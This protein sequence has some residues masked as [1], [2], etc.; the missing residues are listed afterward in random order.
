MSRV[1][2]WVMPYRSGNIFI[3]KCFLIFIFQ[4]SIDHVA[5]LPW[6]IW[7]FY[8]LLIEFRVVNATEYS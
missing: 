6:E 5:G 3:L 8:Q 7:N 2:I 1:Q 4:W